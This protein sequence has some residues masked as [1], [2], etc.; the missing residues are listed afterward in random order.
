MKIIKAGYVILTP[1]D[2]EKILKSIAL[3]GVSLN[4]E[5]MSQPIRSLEISRSHCWTS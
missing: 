4:S 1:I 2:R 3:D 5:R